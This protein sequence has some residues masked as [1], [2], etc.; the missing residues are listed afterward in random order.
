MRKPRALSPS[1]FML[2][3]KE[4]E[5]YI[6]RHLV[7]NRPP[8]QP[9]ALAASVGS[10]FD[11]WVKSCLYADLFGPNHNPDYSFDALFESSVEEHNRDEAR[12]M[13]LHCF[14]NYVETG[15]YDE[16]RDLMKDAKEDPTFETTEVCEID[17]VKLTGKPDARFV[18]KDGVHVILDWKVKG[19]CS[20]YGASPS[21]GYAICRDGFD[22]LD[23]NLTKKNRNL[24]ISGAEVK[25]KHSQSHGKEHK[26]YLAFDFQGITIN[27]AYLETCNEEWAIQLTMYGWMM[28]EEIGDENVVSCIDEVVAKYMGD[29]PKYKDEPNRPLLRVANHRARVSKDF[30]LQLFE[31]LKTLWKSIDDEWIFQGYPKEESDEMFAHI[32]RK[33]NGLASD[34]SEEEDWYSRISRPSYR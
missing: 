9:Q 21:K 4:P 26:S 5:E 14:D 15:S 13:G 24:K 27:E 8:R 31:R 20:K 34:G 1:A 16:L 32:E 19:Y 33:A 17:G 12:L 25:G 22:W 3:E 6:I 7:D 23:R 30:Q 10:A 28:G 18:N 11:S 29:T 2:W